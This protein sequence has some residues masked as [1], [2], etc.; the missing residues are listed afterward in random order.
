MGE[1]HINMSDMEIAQMSIKS[2]KANIT[3]NYQTA[4]NN[5]S[6]MDSFLLKMEFGEVIFKKVDLARIKY[7][8]ADI[9]MGHLILEYGANLHELSTV[10]V[11]VGAGSL[12]LVLPDTEK[13]ILIKINGS[14]FS[15]LRLPPTFIAKKEGYYQN[16]EFADNTEVIV[17]D[18]DVSMGSVQ[19]KLK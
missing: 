16:S 13:H 3:L 18:I 19:V 5:R 4:Q 6:Q 14:S 7:L 2:G 10:K 12:D 8:K 17:F 11:K 9:G 1:T 15:K